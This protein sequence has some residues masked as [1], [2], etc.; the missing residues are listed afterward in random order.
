VRRVREDDGVAMILGFTGTRRGMTPLQRATVDRLFRE[1]QPTALHHGG[2]R[3]ADTEAHRL[4]LDAR[5]NVCV[6]PGPD[7]DFA[8]DCLGAGTVMPVKPNLERNTDIA[9]AGVDGLVAAVAEH[10]E[11]L[12]SGTW[13]TVR[14]ARK[15]GRRIW[16]V[17]PDGTLREEAAR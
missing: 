16:I 13:S 12:R 15:L 14:R 5:V 17:F 10:I 9:A 8:H 4:A 3:H 2:E 6:H 7:F 11:V 1:L